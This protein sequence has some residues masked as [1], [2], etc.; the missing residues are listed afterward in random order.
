VY[1]VNREEMVES[2]LEK[3]ANFIEFFT[4]GVKERS[5]N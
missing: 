3:Y 5:F 2:D 1:G 4:R